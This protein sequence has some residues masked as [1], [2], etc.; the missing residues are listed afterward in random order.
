MSCPL[1]HIKLSENSRAITNTTIPC[2]SRLLQTQENEP[3]PTSHYL[4]LIWPMLVMSLDSLAGW[5]L[6]VMS[7]TTCSLSVPGH[8]WHVCALL[9]LLEYVYRN[10]R[11][12]S[13]MNKGFDFKVVLGWLGGLCGDRMAVVWLYHGSGPAVQV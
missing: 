13:A 9:F 12:K 8:H 1:P 10:D 6:L 5:S 7:E 3:G 11:K 2:S 4:Y